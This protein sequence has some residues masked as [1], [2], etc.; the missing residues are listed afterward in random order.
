MLLPIGKSFTVSG[1][2]N[3]QF[4]GAVTNT[5]SGDVLTS[6]VTGGNS[7]II[8]G[9]VN[10][11]TA[12]TF[13]LAGTGP[14]I[15]GGTVASTGGNLN[16]TNGSTTILSGSNT[17]SGTTTVSGTS[18]V[19]GI[20]GSALGASNLTLNGGVFAYEPV[21]AGPLTT[22]T[23][24]IASGSTIG[25]S[26]GGTA[27]QSAITSAAAAITVAGPVT[28]NI[29]GDPNAAVANGANNGLIQAAS[30]LGNATYKLGTV[31]N[32]SNFTIGGLTASGTA[33]SIA[34]TSQTALTAEYWA[35]GYAGGAN[36]MAITDGSANSNWS[37]TDPTQGAGTIT[38]L[39]PGPTATVYFTGS[40]VNEG[41]MVL[42]ASMSVAG[43]QVSDTNAV[44]LN[45]DGN[46]LTTGT[47][48]ITVNA[49]AGAVTLNS[50]IA[51]SGTQI[52]T[53]NS[54]NL[55]TIGGAVSGTAGSP[56]TI[57]G[58]GTVALSGNNGFTAG[59]NI[60]GGTV[61]AIG[62]AFALGGATGS[63]NVNLV[64]GTTGT[65]LGDSHTFAN[66]IILAGNGT[67]TVG[68][69]VERTTPPSLVEA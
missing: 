66:P 3:I 34:V 62:S 18:T 6:S 58:T 47:G 57:S 24:N 25:T 51:L 10:L 64:S 61:S 8:S 15:I 2:N 33:V 1:V 29:Y 67:L 48:G 23:I 56:L 26:L 60:G 41:S 12:D 46:T 39:T 16:I 38:L 13:T 22:G 4:S 28:V 27:G 21:T 43:I 55:L 45:A 65:L 7:L 49:G 52:W 54:A 20:S 40:S 44:G 35:G 30:G 59:L 17:Y 68:N 36:V 63:G 5:V 14:T 32:A 11:G 31:Y 53:N 50:L 9:S 19:I 37:T 42:G 69:T